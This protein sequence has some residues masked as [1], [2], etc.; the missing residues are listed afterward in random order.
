VPLWHLFFYDSPDVC[1][2]EKRN[3]VEKAVDRQNNGS[4][5]IFGDLKMKISIVVNFPLT[6]PSPYPEPNPTVFQIDPKKDSENQAAKTS[7]RKDPAGETSFKTFV[8]NYN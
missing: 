5:G 3:Q 7:W 1:Y 6:R 8:K 2:T 4:S